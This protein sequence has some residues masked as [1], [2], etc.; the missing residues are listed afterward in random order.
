MEL[1]GSEFNLHFHKPAGRGCAH[2]PW[3]PALMKTLGRYG[4]SPGSGGWEEPE[5]HSCKL[6]LLPLTVQAGGDRCALCVPLQAS[7]S[8][9]H[10]SSR[11]S[12]MRETEIPE[13]ETRS[14]TN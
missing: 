5:E 10:F 13:T 6:A 9:S 4:P 7:F 8:E 3:C 11:F 12:Q 14:D 2:L 1:G